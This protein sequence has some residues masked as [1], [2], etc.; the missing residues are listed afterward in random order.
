MRW[1]RRLAAAKE[2][3][4]RRWIAATDGRRPGLYVLHRAR[5]YLRHACQVLTSALDRRPLGRRRIS[6]AQAE[7]F[8]DA[9]HR[10][11]GGFYAG[12]DH[13]RTS[14]PAVIGRGQGSLQAA[15]RDR[16]ALLHA[17]TTSI[18]SGMRRTMAARATRSRCTSGYSAPCR[19]P[20]ICSLLMQAVLI[21]TPAPRGEA[22]AGLDMAVF[23]CLRPRRQR[24]E[25]PR[26]GRLALDLVL[27][28]VSEDP[29]GETA[30]SS[31]VMFRRRDETRCNSAFFNGLL[32]TDI[33]ADFKSGTLS[34]QV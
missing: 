12:Q 13:Q 33:Y 21:G 8:C 17:P 30:H 29:L 5:A 1:R 22:V 19:R 11:R 23:A 15:R 32:P 25:E 27:Q 4:R 26:S 31:S 34:D 24:Q 18:A 3:S 9:D 28:I 14:D 20:S 16:R 10:R 7:R 6:R 2:P